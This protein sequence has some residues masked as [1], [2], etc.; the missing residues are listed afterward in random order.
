MLGGACEITVNWTPTN[1]HRQLWRICAD[2]S[3]YVPGQK[4]SAGIHT[5]VYTA[6]DACE[7]TSIIPLITVLGAGLKITCPADIV[8]DRIDPNLPG[9]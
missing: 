2:T 1:C 9:A 8:V 4:F 5:V 6:R 7:I 3:N